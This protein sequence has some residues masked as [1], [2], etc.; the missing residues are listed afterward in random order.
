VPVKSIGNAV[1]FQR[2]ILKIPL[3]GR[4]DSEKI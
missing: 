1:D 2:N 4:Q 3:R